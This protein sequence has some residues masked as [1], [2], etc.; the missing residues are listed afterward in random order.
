[1]PNSAKSETAN[2]DLI[3]EEKGLLVTES[4]KR[5]D[6]LIRNNKIHEIIQNLDDFKR[7]S[8]KEIALK[9]IESKGGMVAIARNLRKFQGLDNEVALKLI[10]SK[11]AMAVMGNLEKFQGLDSKVASKLIELGAGAHVARNLEKFQGIDIKRVGDLQTQLRLS[12]SEALYYSLKNE[13]E[14]GQDSIEDQQR[15]VFET[16]K[17]GHSEWR[18]EENIARPFKAGADVFG[19]GKMFEY[20]SR[21][22]LSRHEGLHNFLKIIEIYKASRLEPAAFYNNILGQVCRDNATYE[23]GTAHHHLNS[24]ANNINL[25]FKATRE[26]VKT[27]TGLQ[28]FQE[29]SADLDQDYKIFG[30]WK[31]LKKYQ[32][33]CELLGKAEILDQLQELSGSDNKKLRNYVETLA[34]HPNISMSEVMK[35]WRDPDSFLDINEFHAPR[36]H[37]RKKPSNYTQIPNLDL[38]AAELRDALIDGDYDKLQAFAPMEINYQ[39]L[40]G[41]RIS[42][43]VDLARQL[44]I[45]DLVLREKLG[46][47]PNEQLSRNTQLFSKLNKIFQIHNSDLIKYLGGAIEIDQKL[48]NELEQF[49]D[50]PEIDEY[51][52][53]INLKSDPDGVVAGND[54]A[55]CMPFGSGKNNVYT[56]NP[57]CSLL[58]IQKKNAEGI[59]RTVAQSVLT[60][61]KQIKENVA[62]LVEKMNSTEVRLHEVVSEDALLETPSVITCDNVEVAPNFMGQQ[63]SGEIIAELYQDFFREYVQKYGKAD[64][65]DNQKVIIGMG[66]SDALNNL[67]KTNNTFLPEAPVGYSDNIKNQ[68]YLL[69]LTKKRRTGLVLKK[70][71]APEVDCR[72]K[73]DESH[74][75]KGVK[76]LTYRD[77]LAVAYIEGKA[78]AENESL[79]QNLHNMENALIAKDVNNQAKKRTNL[80]FKYIDDKGKIHGYLLAYEGVK[81]D[82]GGGYHETENS[83]EKV[84]YVSDLA[85]DGQSKKTGGSLMLAFAKQY[86]ER[87][88]AKDNPLPIYM[89]LRDSTSYPIIIKQFENLTRGTNYTCRLNETGQYQH[90]NDT[91]HEVMIIVEKSK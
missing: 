23:D 42:L 21:P 8:H 5:L 41:E 16:L 74:L 52:I 77:S 60:P 3:P 11:G 89:Q 2:Q 20:L 54:T 39:V 57:A 29:L 26:R 50:N 43:R 80:S 69:D 36:E 25:D 63:H 22:K 72:E 19:Y 83:P 14:F 58:T 59:Y 61:D 55:C 40:R 67:P 49:R 46:I 71:I 90:G 66:Y 9:I 47:N 48:E 33:I 28:K 81:S 76:F 86:Q 87:Y 7:L 18:D 4:L 1:M 62:D 17:S 12:R 34:F 27:Y 38:S 10:E 6:E 24:T 78:Y 13:T 64:N 84:I 15:F 32:E 85:S 75:P 56:F 79:I 53:K 44:G 51:K 91:M 45:Q 35:F 37:N 82:S 31:N 30:S 68:A 73:Q 70:E 88:L 65:L